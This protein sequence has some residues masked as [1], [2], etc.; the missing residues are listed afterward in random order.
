MMRKEFSSTLL[1]KFFGTCSMTPYGKIS[2]WHIPM[3]LMG[4]LMLAIAAPAVRAQQTQQSVSPPMSYE[5]MPT[6]EKSKQE[7]NWF[8]A[9]CWYL[10]NR[11]MDLTDVPRFY[12]TIGDGLGAT[13]RITKY[14]YAS[15]F[16]DH[17]RCFGW[18]KRTPPWFD[19]HIE[20]R[21]F[22]FLAAHE[23]EL[24]R[25]PTEV[26]ISL[27]F[28]LLGINLALSGSEAVDF[29]SGIAGIDLV[30]DDHGPVMHDYTEEDQ[31]QKELQRAVYGPQN[32]PKKPGEK[33][34]PATMEESQPPARVAPPAPTGEMQGGAA[35]PGPVSI[36]PPPQ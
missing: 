27:H 7:M 6:P 23:G 22:G 30:G 24:D 26:G 13:L 12:L 9:V 18:T 11:L 10:P 29:F 35:A 21:Y 1:G 25:D 2:G 28:L 4:A 32:P 17:A 36:P 3:L 16:E 34:N 14:C 8:S 19:E 5:P 20:E 33:P 15:W 31:A